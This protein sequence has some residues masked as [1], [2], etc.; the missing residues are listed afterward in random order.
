MKTKQLARKAREI[1]SIETAEALWHLVKAHPFKAN[2][3]M[4][5]PH[6]DIFTVRKRNGSPRTIEDPSDELKI[7]QN[8]LNDYLQPLYFF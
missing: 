1:S 2:V 5:H 7:I 6:Y 8:R 4:Q 3:L